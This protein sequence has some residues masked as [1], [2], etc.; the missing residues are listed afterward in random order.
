MRGLCLF[1]SAVIASVAQRNQAPFHWS[2]RVSGVT[3]ANSQRLRTRV[4]IEV[5]G[6]ELIKRR[7]EGELVF[8]VEFKDSDGRVFTGLGIENGEVD[9]IFARQHQGGL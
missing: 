4:E 1:L 8:L 2:A 3:L 6:N 9:P 7:G 5:D